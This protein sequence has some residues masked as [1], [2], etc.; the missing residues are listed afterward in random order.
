M[1][2][3]CSFGGKDEEEMNIDELAK[4]KDKEITIENILND[5]D[6]TPNNDNQI[7][8]QISTREI[9]NDLFL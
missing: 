5:N 1:S 9:N 3:E 4:V 6:I 2:L 7:F 8:N